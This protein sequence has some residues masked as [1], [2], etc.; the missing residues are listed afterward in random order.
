MAGIFHTG[1]IDRQTE[2]SATELTLRK[3]PSSPEKLGK[4]R[5]LSPIFRA[6]RNESISSVDAPLA[7]TE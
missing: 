5:M 3:F 1:E 4:L 6:P 7:A 2:V